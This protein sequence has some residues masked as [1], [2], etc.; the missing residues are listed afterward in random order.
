[1]RV[2]AR[3]L[4]RQARP[5]A[6]QTRHSMTSARSLHSSVA[7][8]A[9]DKPET[10]PARIPHEPSSCPANTVMAGLN[11]LKDQP[12]VLAL[13]DEEYPDWLWTITSPKPIPDDGPG[14]KGE[15]MRMR[16]E[17]RK[18]IKDQNFMSKQ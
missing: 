16:M 12:P 1:M 15:K 11:Y 7:R 6:S 3:T 17:N 13:P 8:R 5:L 10:S 14:G 9:E 2:L 18:L 4:C